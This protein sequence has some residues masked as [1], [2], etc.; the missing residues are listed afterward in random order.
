MSYGA[1][2]SGKI[3]RL[4]RL[5][6]TQKSRILILPLDDAL[7][8][9]SIR[10]ESDTRALLRKITANPPDAIMGYMGMFRNFAPMLSAI[11]AIM[12]ITASTVKS[13]H[14][15]KVLVS[16]VEKSLSM[17]MD[18]IAVHVNIG[19]K[20]ESEMLS[21]LGQVASE[22]EILGMPLMGIMYPRSEGSDGDENYFDEREN[23]PEV[24]AE[25]MTHAAMVG[26]ELGC[27]IIKTHYTG[28]PESFAQ[29]V[30]SCDP[31]PVTAAGGSVVSLDRILDTAYSVISA[32]GAGISF[33]RNVVS[34]PNI[35]STMTRLKAIV[36]HGM[37]V[38]EA[39]QMEAADT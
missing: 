24:Y 38:Q 12:H 1:T 20:Y 35:H 34:R 29:L 13:T 14:T 31:V 23:H 11:P 8:G 16:S 25:R 10:E 37:T 36:H 21:I 6:P 18:M 7:I 17:G 2:H 39:L 28:T 5:F 4:S 33:G 19:S 22:C 3:R 26:V 9:G 27:D 32:G 30:C 15:R